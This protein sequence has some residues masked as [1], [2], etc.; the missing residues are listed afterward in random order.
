MYCYEFPMV[1]I[2]VDCVIFKFGSPSEVLL[3]KRKNEPYKGEYALPGG[4][5]NAEMEKVLDAVKREVEE[6]TSLSLSKF[7]FVNFF[8]NPDRDKR[9]RTISFCYVSSVT[10]CEPI[11][12]DDAESLEWVAYGD[13]IDGKVILAFDHKKMIEQAWYNY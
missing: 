7:K 6:E 5:V 9:V 13:I 12:G 3:I 4:Y 10:D 1:S 8:D 2:T 11:A